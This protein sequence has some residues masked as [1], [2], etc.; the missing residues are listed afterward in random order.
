MNQ[1]AQATIVS[2][3]MN[4]KPCKDGS[5]FNFII[6]FVDNFRFITSGVE[7]QQNHQG[8][9]I[10]KNAILP[11]LKGSN[12]QDKGAPLAIWNLHHE[13]VTLM[14]SLRMTLEA[15]HSF[16]RLEARKTWSCMTPWIEK[17][18]KIFDQNQ[19]SEECVEDLVH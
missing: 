4:W 7:L 16:E 19:L 10:R 14:P 17:K 11:S 6:L 2:N 12:F 8:A 15:V 1:I 3:A 13:D 9:R 5:V 18:E